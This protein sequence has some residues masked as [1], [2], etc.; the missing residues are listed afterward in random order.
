MLNV[1]E[2]NILYL[3]YN[4]KGF[5]IKKKSDIVCWFNF[6]MGI[7]FVEDNSYYARLNNLYFL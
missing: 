2:N 3:F 4:R 7:T 1:I 5:H 6:G